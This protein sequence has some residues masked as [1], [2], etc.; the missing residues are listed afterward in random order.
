MGRAYLMGA[1]AG[2]VLGAGG[3]VFVGFVTFEQTGIAFPTLVVPSLLLGALGA[4]IGG[5]HGA[6]FALAQ[7]PDKL[8]R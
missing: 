3:L 7:D 1:A 6:L 2:F 8:K 5:L 4:A